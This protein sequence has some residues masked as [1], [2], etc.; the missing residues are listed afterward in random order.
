[1]SFYVIETVCTTAV[2]THMEESVHGCGGVGGAC[3]RGWGRWNTIIK[4]IKSK[5]PTCYFSSVVKYMCHPLFSSVKVNVFWLE[6]LYSCNFQKKNI[7]EWD[8][9]FY[10]SWSVRY[11]VI[12]FTQSPAD[13]AGVGTFP[14]PFT[15]CT[16]I[17]CHLM[18]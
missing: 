10:W 12:L 9:I 11:C 17:F 8:L 18:Q 1:M 13:T 16:S 4:L 5:N 6:S 14:A 2:I 7:C 3:V 15:F